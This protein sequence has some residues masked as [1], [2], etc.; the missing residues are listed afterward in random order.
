VPLDS[1]HA[2]GVA[3]GQH[4]LVTASAA[5]GLHS[6]VVAAVLLQVWQVGRLDGLPLLCALTKNTCESICW[7]TGRLRMGHS[8][9]LLH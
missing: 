3:R 1:G 8:L 4:G 6:V 9:V 7:P 5:Q 2:T